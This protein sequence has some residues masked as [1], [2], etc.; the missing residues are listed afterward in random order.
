MAEPK[1][2]PAGPATTEPAMREPNALYQ[3]GKLAGRAVGFEVDEIGK[4]VRFDVIENTEDLL[5]PDECEF[6]KFNLVVRK[7]GYATKVAHDSPH[8][9]RILRGVVAEIVGYRE[10]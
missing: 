10:Q 2:T 8:K 4:E 5:L 1:M 3:R 6:Q 9:G 7:I